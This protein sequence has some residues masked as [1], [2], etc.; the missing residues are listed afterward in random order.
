LSLAI[1]AVVGAILYS[2]EVELALFFAC[3]TFILNFIPNF[4]PMIAVLLPLPSV[5]LADPSL[6]KISLLILLPGTI[7]FIFGNIIETKLQGDILSLHP[8]TV[9]FALLFWGLLWGIPG[10]FLAT[11]L[12]CIIKLVLEKFSTTRWVALLMEGIW[13]SGQEKQSFYLN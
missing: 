10:M 8:V 5:F 11:P 12:T 3:L 1:S 13:P 6:F 2:L 7:H 4:G 9:L